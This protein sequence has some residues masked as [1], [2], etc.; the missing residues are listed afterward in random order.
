MPIG[1]EAHGVA[2]GL[3]PCQERRT[4][5]EGEAAG[6]RQHRHRYA[7]SSSPQPLI[8]DHRRQ[9]QQR[10]ELGGGARGE[11][12]RGHGRA[13][14]L[15]G[16]EGQRGKCCRGQID[17]VDD[18][19]AE[20]DHG[21]RVEHQD[22]H[23][24]Q[25]GAARNGVERSHDD[26]V[27]HGALHEEQ[28]A[29]VQEADGEDVRHQHEEQAA[30]RVFEQEITVRHCS[31]QCPSAV[32]EEEPQV[33]VEHEILARIGEDDEQERQVQPRGDPQEHHVHDRPPRRGLCASTRPVQGFRDLPCWRPDRLYN[34]LRPCHALQQL[35]LFVG[36]AA[37][38]WAASA[39]R[40]RPRCIASRAAV[41]M[42]RAARASPF[43]TSR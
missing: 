23:G 39:S 21:Q 18:E 14:A 12:H 33:A 24:R 13:I 36:S 3:W 26:H 9:Q 7:P 4:E 31:G 32:V 27:E 16:Q 29:V 8:H 37:R 38:S 11:S 15:P 5:E 28:R 41:T 20:R 22:A 30:G 17:T 6:E 43:S 25:P 1:L 19:R 10:I 35:G 34:T 42:V 2:K 40:S